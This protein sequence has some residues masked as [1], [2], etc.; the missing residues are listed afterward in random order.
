MRTTELVERLDKQVAPLIGWIRLRGRKVSCESTFVS[1][2][3]QA[4]PSS[5]YLPW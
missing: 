4:S 5:L 1:I 3:L 2:P